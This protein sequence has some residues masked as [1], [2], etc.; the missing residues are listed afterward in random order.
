MTDPPRKLRAR[1]KREAGAADLQDDAG[2]SASA[3]RQT[4][5][6]R[7]ARTTPGVDMSCQQACAWGTNGNNLQDVNE[8]DT[9]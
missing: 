5:G 8:S 4:S 7:R 9:A 3:P 1:P 6:R 2:P